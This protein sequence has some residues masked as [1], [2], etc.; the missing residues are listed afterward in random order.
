M[1]VEKTK[2]QIASKLSVYQNNQALHPEIASINQF[3]QNK[4]RHNQE[5]REKSLSK[6]EEL[7]VRF[8]VEQRSKDLIVRE[9]ERIMSGLYGI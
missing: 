7:G 3:I 5:A 1:A 8:N 9:K 2:A 4:K 6:L